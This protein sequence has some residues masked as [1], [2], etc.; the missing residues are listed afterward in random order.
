MLWLTLIEKWWA[1]VAS[2]DE[3]GGFHSIWNYFIPI[4]L[5]NQTIIDNNIFLIGQILFS[6]LLSCF[7]CFFCQP[8]RRTT[9]FD[10]SLM[11]S[12]NNIILRVLDTR[13]WTDSSNVEMLG[14]SEI[15]FVL[16]V[17]NSI[18]A[19]IPIQLSFLSNETNDI[20]SSIRTL[21]RIQY[22]S[23]SSSY[24]FNIM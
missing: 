2:D 21:V 4:D 1:S 20:L 12:D 19:F 5:T 11:F 24:S 18:V 14:I 13:Y 22:V 7:F 9:I 17:V 16:V 10:I 6:F 23:S 15:A 8:N 3:T